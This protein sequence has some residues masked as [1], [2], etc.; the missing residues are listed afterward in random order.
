MNRD[1]LVALVLM[2]FSG[3][4]WLGADGIRESSIDTGVGAQALPK[5]LAYALAGLSVLLMGQAIA[6]RFAPMEA[7]ATEK[8]SPQTPKQ[9]LRAAG[10]LS[11]GA[12]YLVIVSYTGYFL[13]LVFLILAT[14]VYMGKAMSAR[15]LSV[16]AGGAAFYWLLFVKILKIPMPEGIWRSIWQLVGS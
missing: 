4:Y 9:V 3:L 10:M 13:G 6:H 8:I 2:A 16:A 11:I 5:A 14:A 12:A 7:E 1:V 15:L